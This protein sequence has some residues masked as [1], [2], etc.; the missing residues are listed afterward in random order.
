MRGLNRSSIR[1]AET[2]P[3]PT[4]CSLCH[5]TLEYLVN[6][7][8]PWSADAYAL[9]PYCHPMAKAPARRAPEPATTQQGA[10]PEP[11]AWMRRWAYDGVNVMAMKKDDRPQGWSFDATSEERF[12]NDDVPLY[13]TQPERS[14]DAVRK[15][16]RALAEQFDEMSWAASRDG[17]TY[18]RD[19]WQNAASQTR[20]R[21]KDQ[22]W[23]DA[24][25]LANGARPGEE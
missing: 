16:L 12:L 10:K 25:M 15:V 5:G 3:M 20:S 13:D 11:R 6:A 4:D 7:A 1:L 21:M 19:V 22:S 17:E 14:G 24:A 8:E 9:C 23:I 2:M 18:R